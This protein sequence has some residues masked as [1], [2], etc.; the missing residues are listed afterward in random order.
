MDG[1]WIAV[2]EDEAEM[3]YMIFNEDGTGYDYD[4]GPITYTYDEES[5]IMTLTCDDYI[6]SWNYEFVKSTEIIAT[7]IDAEMT[8]RLVKDLSYRIK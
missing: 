8:F 6:E 4:L 2:P 3:L 5:G 7:C 1:E